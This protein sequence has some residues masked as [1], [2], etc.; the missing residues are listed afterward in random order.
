[1]SFGSFGSSN[2]RRLTLELRAGLSLLKSDLV[3]AKGLIDQFG[4]Q[5]EQDDTAHQRRLSAEQLRALR[6]SHADQAHEH[7]RA[8]RAAADEYEKHLGQ[9]FFSKLARAATKSWRDGF[10]V[11]GETFGGGGSGGLLSGALSVAGGNLLT[12]ILGGVTSQVTG[13]VKAGFDYNKLKEQTLLGFEI[14]LKGRK[15]AED[16]FNQVALFAEKTP[17]ELDQ[18]LMGVQRLMATFSAPEALQTIQ[19]VTDAVA[20]QGKVGGEATEQINGI[21]LALQQIVLKQKVSAEEMTQLAERQVNGWKYLADEIARTDKQFAALTG[22]ERIARVMEMS[23]KGMLNAKTAVA[24]IVKGMHQEFGGTAERIANETAE[25]IESNISDSL[26]RTAGVASESAFQEYKKFLERV[27]AFLQTGAAE[28]IA[29]G[30]SGT[31][32]GLFSGFE[33]TLAAIQSGNIQQLGLDAVTSAKDGAVR[34]AQGLYDAGVNAA[35]QLEQGWRDKLDQHSPSQVM[36]NLGY[37]AGLSLIS[38]FIQG[39]KGDALREQIDKIIEEVAAKYGIDPNLIRAV[40]KKESSFNPKALSPKGAEGL[41]QLMPGTAARYG[42]TNSFDPRQNIEG[43]THYLA[44]LLKRFD[45]D[46][47]LALAAYNAGEGRKNSATPEA[48]L[49]SL[50]E[51]KAGV[52]DYV[53]SIIRDYTRLQTGVDSS[54]SALNNFTNAIRNTTAETS[55]FEKQL[56]ELNRQKLDHLETLQ[57]RQQGYGREYKFIQDEL[58]KPENSPTGANI[59]NRAE[60]LA[61]RR[62]LDGL[63]DSTAKEYESYWLDIEKQMAALRD[64]ITG[65]RAAAQSSAAAVVGGDGAFAN[66]TDEQAQHVLEIINRAAVGTGELKQ[67]VGLLATTVT[68]QALE[69]V[70]IIAK[71]T[72]DAFGN[73]PPLVKQSGK[74]TEKE[75]ADVAK[76]ISGMFGGLLQSTLRGQWREGLKGLRDDFLSW[77]ASLA[78]DWFESKIFKSLMSLGK[79][80]SG[81]SSGGGLLNSIKSLFGFGGGSKTDAGGIFSGADPSNPGILHLLGLSSAAGGASA[82]AFPVS[83]LT[84]AGLL[85]A[86]PFASTA[87]GLGAGAALPVSGLT[88]DSILGSLPG[89]TGAGASGGMGASL[90]ALASNPLT[91][92]AAGGALAGFAL[93]K[94]FSHRTEKALRKAIQQ[95]YS[96]DIS[97]MGVLK[98]IKQLGEQAF[99]RGQVQKHLAETIQLEPVRE[100]IDSYAASTGQAHTPTLPHEFLYNDIAGPPASPIT[101]NGSKLMPSPFSG[102]ARLPRAGG[103]AG[104][105]LGAL[106]AEVRNMARAVIESGAQTT[107]ILGSAVV[108][109]TKA[110]KNITS[111]DP[112]ALFKKAISDNPG[113][114]FYAWHE[115]FSRHPV[116]FAQNVLGPLGV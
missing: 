60:L 12:S 98:Q 85:G 113:D 56:A 82:G 65:L 33:K 53:F 61:R 52:H 106:V 74:E 112:D 27:L 23:Q 6:R 92:I 63:M 81:S 94:H 39:A 104:A 105:G 41:M 8:A 38:G 103:D 24:V 14:K 115:G 49:N 75:M 44:D 26:H 22:E 11:G 20:G 84:T 19:A 91:W 13:G 29:G 86:L 76:S 57:L 37:G 100:M 36:H 34:G 3:E 21:G 88:A 69:S 25:G 43:G 28:K 114:V 9:G 67:E 54:M 83:G 32:G 97:D 30:I 89:A 93:W 16:F 96:V 64:K 107:R 55:T 102:A 58:R 99:G 40:I 87:A 50:I 109:N 2:T 4:R 46:L 5:V 116:F 1:M 73:L 17:L 90:I 59:A 79:S 108:E 66:I 101:V 51:N 72:G 15:E 10:K 42:V 48:R 71:E 31:T 7:T 80:K 47:R 45:G 18:A 78:Q 70:K 95:S 68:P 77:A 111:A 110:L 62:E 35:G